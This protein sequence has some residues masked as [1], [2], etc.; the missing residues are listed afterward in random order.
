MTT[1]TVKQL[2]NGEFVESTTSE[3]IDL[4][5]PAT[6]QVIAKVP[7]TTP[8]EI[9]Q[10]VAAAAEAFKTWRKTP[11]NTRSRIFLKYQQLIRDNMDELAAM[12]T[13]EQGKTLADAKGDVFRGL[14]VVE[15]A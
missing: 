3:W 8:D 6:Q 12:L 7:Q 5:N 13:E 1:Q 2:I 14:E 11:I 15:H 9:N 10:A 4:T